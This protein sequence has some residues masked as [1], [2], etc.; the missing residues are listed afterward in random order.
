[1]A[2]RKSDPVFDFLASP[3]KKRKLRKDKVAKLVKKV[4]PVKTTLGYI[5][6]GK[7]KPK[8]SKHVKGMRS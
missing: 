8:K 2:K 1:M 6:T 3:F 7:N 5:I 4:K